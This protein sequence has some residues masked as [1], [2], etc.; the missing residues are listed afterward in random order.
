M[1]RTLEQIYTDNPITTNQSTD[2]MYFAQSPYTPGHDAGMTFA[3]FA[4]QFG[5]PFTPSALTKTDDTN[6]TLTL[7]GTPST[8]LLKTVSLTLGW[9]GLLSPTRGGTGVNNGTSTLT[10]AG[11]LATSGA[12]ATTFTMTGATSV[13]FPTSGTL[14]TSASAVTILT[15]TANQTTVSAATGAVTV[16]L[17]SN[18][19]LPGTGGVTL[20][21]GTT[22]QRAGIA[23]TMRFNS[24][25]SV[26]EF[27]TDGATW[28]TIESSATTVTSVSGTLNRIT[29]T[30][31]TT[32]VIDISVS[33]VGQSSITTLGTIGTGTWQGTVIG[34]TYG[35][36]GVNNGSNTLTLAGNLSTVGAFASVFNFTGAT[37][38][39]FPTSG[40]LSTTTGTVTSVS[41][42]TNRITSTGGATPVIDIS[43]SYV[44]QS[45]ITTL[46]T[47][48]S[49]TWTGTTIAV[50]NGGTGITSFGTGVAT[51]LGQNVTGSGSMVLANGP[52]FVTSTITAP[53]ITFS[54]TSEIIGT[55]TNNNASAGSVGEFLSS[56]AAPGTSLSSTVSVDGTSLSLTA[57]DWDVW[58]SCYFSGLTMTILTTWISVTS[59]TQPD[60]GLTGSIGATNLQSSNVLALMQ[61]ISL[62]GTT[63]VYISANGTFTGA[64][65]LNRA[66]IYARRVR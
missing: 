3:N 29:S 18:A 57:G 8:A 16:G 53:S 25:T 21:T 28:V 2:L 20:P 42:T 60:I 36:T 34:A 50:A 48:T 54:S 59:A 56:A 35:G 1:S 45:S 62:S 63:T 5:A 51:A 58:G 61:R 19:I 12:F 6:V 46:G 47:I 52:T 24:Q 30:G 44:G 64:C 27:T 17:A 55:T 66:T 11:N 22:A 10:L 37:N 38:V 4:A 23:G 40:T 65:S 32:P 41:G 43:S 33:Y 13:T 14:L 49:G 9:T 39:T 26:F 15:A 31:G 7:G